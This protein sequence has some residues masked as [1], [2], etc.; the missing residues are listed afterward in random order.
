L[1]LTRRAVWLAILLILTAF[2]S[3]AAFHLLADPVP[4]DQAI[5]TT[6]VGNWIRVI[7]NFSILAVGSTGAVLYM[8]SRLERSLEESGVLLKALDEEA[9]QKWAAITERLVLEEQ[10]QH[11][12]RLESLGRLAG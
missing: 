8:L 6:Q 12:Q 10:L 7:G 11:A 9:A 1:I 3:F 2:A 5:D 4:T